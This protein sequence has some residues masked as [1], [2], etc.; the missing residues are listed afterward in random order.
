LET[1]FLLTDIAPRNSNGSG[2]EKVIHKP[3]FRGL[4][5]FSACFRSGNIPNLPLHYIKY[6]N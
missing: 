2:G 6:E 3:P 1:S 4:N 5:R